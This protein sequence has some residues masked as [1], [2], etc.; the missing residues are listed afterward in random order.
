MSC[1][2][3][4]MPAGPDCAGTHGPRAGLGFISRQRS[5]ACAAC[6][7]VLACCDFSSRRLWHTSSP[8]RRRS[9]ARADCMP[10]RNVPIPA[11]RAASE[12]APRAASEGANRGELRC[13]SGL[14]STGCT[15]VGHLTQ[16]CSGLMQQLPS[17]ELGCLGRL[18][19]PGRI[20]VANLMQFMG[21][22]VS[23]CPRVGCP[24][25]APGV[26][27]TVRADCWVQPCRKPDAAMCEV[28]TAPPQ[29]LSAM[30]EQTAAR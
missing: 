24:A 3:H 18:L 22:E 11:P 4:C 20:Y 21:S 14:L 26:V 30:H 28:S 16:Q 13:L 2:A 27:C 1:L 19:R 29:V 6:T 10:V 15:R 7:G 25:L 12:G 5:L 23:S 8:R 17:E 9:A